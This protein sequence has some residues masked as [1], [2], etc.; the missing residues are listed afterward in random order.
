ML[1]LENY[2]GDNLLKQNCKVGRIYKQCEASKLC[3]PEAEFGMIENC[4]DCNKKL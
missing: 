4:K 3:N 2:K 1:V